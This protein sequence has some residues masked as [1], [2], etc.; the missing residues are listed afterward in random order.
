MIVSSDKKVFFRKNLLGGFNK[1]DVIDYLAAQSR[2]QLSEKEGLKRE[3][4]EKEKKIRELSERLANYENEFVRL[5]K[6][7]ADKESVCAAAAEET[8]ALKKKLADKTAE[9]EMLAENLSL[10]NQMRGAVEQKL[11]KIYTELRAVA[12]SN[13]SENEDIQIKDEQI[14]RLK[15]QI[16]ALADE[17]T[18][19]TEKINKLTEY[20]N[21]IA[22]L[23]GQ[24][25]APDASSEHN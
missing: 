1:A 21:K 18:K 25:S 24:M 16:S 22:E 2:E 7:I 10:A 5:N 17:N 13:L 4:N 6:Q 8:E 14:A 3:I 11:E 19:L 9:A 12:G 23:L 15:T 20:N